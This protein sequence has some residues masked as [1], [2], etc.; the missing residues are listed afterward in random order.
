MEMQT[1]EIQTRPKWTSKQLDAFLLLRDYP[2]VLLYGGSRSGKTRVHVEFDVTACLEFPGLRGLIVRERRNAAKD[3]VWHETLLAEVLPRYPREIWDDNKSDLYITFANGSEIWVSGTDDQ[4][5]IEKILGRGVGFAYL[6]EA[7]QISYKAFSLIRT[8]LAQK[9][10]GWVPRMQVDCNPPGPKHWLHRVFIDHVEPV[11]GK[12]L[13]PRKYASLLM[14]PIDNREN[15][16]DGYLDDLDELPENE[17]RR[18]KLGEWVKPT[19]AI[20]PE[21]GSHMLIDRADIPDCERYIVGVDMVTYAAVLIGL[22][23]YRKGNEIRHKVYI[24]DSWGRGEALAWEAN[25]AIREKW[26]HYDYVAYI[27]HN[28][29]KAGTREFDRSRLAVKGQGSVE[30]GIIQLQTIMH[31]DD[32]RV[33]KHCAEV[34]YE[35]ENYHRDENGAVVKQDD[36]YIDACRMAVYSTIRKRRIIDN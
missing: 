14:N 6:N 33:A 36:H 22:Q 27:D 35:F 11:D 21:Y 31:Q 34:N 23:R 2:R 9:I 4:A 20:F 24:V 8:R 1:A 5:R 32:F 30:A 26:A 28:L 7:S 25:A 16:P 13:D 3:T 18:F 10:A 19:G 12:R 29:G 17:R 15:L